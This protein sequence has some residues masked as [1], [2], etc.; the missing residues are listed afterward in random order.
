MPNRD[1]DQELHRQLV[2]Y[3]IDDGPNGERLPVCAIFP[4]ELDDAAGIAALA[5][6][7][8]IDAGMSFKDFLRL[9]SQAG[10][11]EPLLLARE[12]AENP[13]HRPPYEWKKHY[14]CTAESLWRRVL[15]FQKMSQKFSMSKRSRAEIV[16]MTLRY[17]REK[18]GKRPFSISRINRDAESLRQTMRPPKATRGK[19]TDS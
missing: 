3:S 5:E 16:R 7:A 11:L 10:P 9:V 18:M 12:R 15:L 17:R 19:S 1:L 6:A 14:G 8:A 2:A 13:P 4:R